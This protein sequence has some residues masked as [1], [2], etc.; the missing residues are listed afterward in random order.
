MPEGGPSAGQA[1]FVMCAEKLDKLQL[2]KQK[3]I[4]G[5]STG[6]VI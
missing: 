6:G 3:Y 1:F 5:K 2:S 4:A